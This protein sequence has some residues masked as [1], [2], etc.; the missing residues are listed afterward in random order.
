[1]ATHAD[2]VAE[3]AA[4][5]FKIPKRAAVLLMNNRT[6]VDSFETFLEMLE[7]FRLD[8]TFQE[9][10]AQEKYKEVDQYCMHRR[11]IP[12]LAEAM[13]ETLRRTNP[14]LYQAAPKD[15][16]YG[17]DNKAYIA[18]LDKFLSS[19]IGKTFGKEIA[20]SGSQGMGTPN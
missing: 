13:G 15:A 2:K 9:V 7:H 18:A 8:A 14:K 6:G 19:S 1:M 3:K 16:E 11:E 5:E 17:D 12:L 20:I 4:Q 10:L